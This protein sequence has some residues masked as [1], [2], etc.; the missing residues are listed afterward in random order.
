MILLS[1]ELWLLANNSESFANGIK[2]IIKNNWGLWKHCN[3]TY[4]ELSKTL[5]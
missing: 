4:L 3:L 5:L 1:D 2:P